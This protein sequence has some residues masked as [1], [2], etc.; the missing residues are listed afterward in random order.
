MPSFPTSHLLC[1][2]GWGWGLWDGGG[3]GRAS[4]RRCR[5]RGSRN[6]YSPT[7][8]HTGELASTLGDDILSVFFHSVLADLVELVIAASMPTLSNIFFLSLAL[9]EEMLAKATSS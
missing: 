6:S 5:A 1:C 2:S 4:R 8:R 3:A 9:G 7:Y